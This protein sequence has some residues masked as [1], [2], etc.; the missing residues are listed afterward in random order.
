MSFT[1]GLHYSI[2]PILRLTSNAFHRH[3][4]VT[5][6]SAII[7]DS[8]RQAAG[9]ALVTLVQ[10]ETVVRWMPLRTNLQDLQLRALNIETRRRPSRLER[11]LSMLVLL[12]LGGIGVTVFGLQFRHNPANESLLMH[13]TFPLAPPPDGMARGIG[14]AAPDNL[15]PSGP[16][17]VFSPENLSDK[18]DGK[19]EFYLSSG[20]VRLTTQRFRLKIPAGAWIEVFQYDMGKPRNGFAVYSGQLRDDAVRLDL[21]PFSYRTEN[22][23]F[24]LD[25]HTYV[26]IIGSGGTQAETAAR[27]AVAKAILA[28]SPDSSEG[29][30]EFHLFPEPFLNRAS[31]SLISADAF[32]FKGFDNVFTASYEMDHMVVTVFLS[33]RE[34]PS[35]ATSVALAYYAFLMENGGRAVASSAFNPETTHLV[36]ILDEFELIITE[37]KILAGVREAPDQATAERLGR[38]LVDHIAES[39]RTGKTPP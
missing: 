23:H 14:F 32:G 11:G 16:V 37:G 33:R 9:N 4:T 38:L 36:E 25:G 15:A 35:E 19:A 3:L 18:I 20:V 7:E 6:A 1:P 5:V 39:R 12:I 24:F 22:G 10:G 29:F 26:E 27:E 2:T 13:G 8:S 28:A 31:I 17:E 34:S 30:D 21:A